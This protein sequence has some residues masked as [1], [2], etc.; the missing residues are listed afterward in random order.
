[1]GTPSVHGDE[2]GSLMPGSPT[3]SARGGPVIPN[4]NLDADM[5]EDNKSQIQNAGGEDR[6]VSGWLS[7]VV[8]R[9]RADSNGSGQGRY[10]ALGQSEEGGRNASPSGRNI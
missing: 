7:R 1:M 5:D 4:L 10:T 8:G 9:G 2:T 6:S 3:E